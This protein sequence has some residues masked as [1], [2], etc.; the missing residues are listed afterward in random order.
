MNHATYY[1]YLG[2]SSV[3]CGNFVTTEYL[4]LDMRPGKRYPNVLINHR[5]SPKRNIIFRGN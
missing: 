5:L 4:T 3:L 1:T 2:G